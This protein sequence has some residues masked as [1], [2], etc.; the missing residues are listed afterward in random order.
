MTV[1]FSC[2]KRDSVIERAADF[3]GRL[4]YTGKD[5][6]CRIDLKSFADLELARTAD[7]YIA[8]AVRKNGEQEWVGLDRIADIHC[9]SERFPDQL[10][11]ADKVL[12]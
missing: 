10:H 9:F 7:F 2:E 4:V 5:D 6:P 3:F 12:F 1:A 8:E 11:P